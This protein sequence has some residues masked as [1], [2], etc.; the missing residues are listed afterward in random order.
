MIA[1]SSKKISK[2]I[3]NGKN[4]CRV[5]VGTKIVYDKFRPTPKYNS[6]IRF[7]SGISYNSL[8]GEKE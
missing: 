5:Y 4:I 3:A 1:I 8:S 6:G 2:I 7:N